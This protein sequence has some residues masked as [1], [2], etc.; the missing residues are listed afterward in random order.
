MNDNNPVIFSN[1]WYAAVNANH[2]KSIMDKQCVACTMS[3]PDSMSPAVIELVTPDM[4][5]AFVSLVSSHDI[6]QDTPK[7]THEI[8]ENHV[9]FISM[10]KINKVTTTDN[11]V[12]VVKPDRVNVIHSSSKNNKKVE[13]HWD[14]EWDWATRREFTV[15]YDKY[16]RV[17]SI[18]GEHTVRDD[19]SEKNPNPAEHRLTT[20]ETYEYFDNVMISTVSGGI[21]G[22]P[23]YKV[24]SSVSVANEHGIICKY[25]TLDAGVSQGNST[26]GFNLMTDGVVAGNMASNGSMI[27]HHYIDSDVF[28]IG[29]IIKLCTVMNPAFDEYLGFERLIMDE[30]PSRFQE[31]IYGKKK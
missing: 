23:S 16:D 21:D 20:D 6:P 3:D 18:R 4:P 27:W 5:N 10:L 17:T 24:S 19:P 8:L 25:M 12:I 1:E 13:L 9:P 11:I 2:A 29:F 28:S 14:H 7:I 30:N 22:L 15:K 26:I 31:R